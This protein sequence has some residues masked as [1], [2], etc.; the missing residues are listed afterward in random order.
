[1]VRRAPALGLMLAAL[2]LAGSVS[3]ASANARPPSPGSKLL[4]Y[5]WNYRNGQLRPYVSGVSLSGVSGQTGVVVN[6]HDS[7]HDRPPFAKAA[8]LIC[9]VAEA[10]AKNLHIG[11]IS[12]VRVW[13]VDGHPVAHC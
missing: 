11:T 8:Q 12:A 9:R 10:G 7:L 1:M 5:L 6:V 4:N 3:I 13:S 2:A